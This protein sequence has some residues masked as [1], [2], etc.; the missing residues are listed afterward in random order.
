MTNDVGCF[1]SDL[2]EKEGCHYPLLFSACKKF[3][4]VA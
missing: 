1:S 2:T 3:E 4:L